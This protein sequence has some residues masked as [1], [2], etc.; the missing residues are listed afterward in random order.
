MIKNIIPVTLVILPPTVP[1]VMKSIV[2]KII[3]G[4]S[5]LTVS[6]FTLR[7]VITEVIPRISRIFMI[8]LP[9][10]FPMDIPLFP[11]NAALILT[12]ASGALVPIATMVR[13][14]TI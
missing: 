7:T 3:N 4:I 8:L 5:I 1:Q 2:E 14:I 11:L 10:T 13:P 9:S 12:A 6:L